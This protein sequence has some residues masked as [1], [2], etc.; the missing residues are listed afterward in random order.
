MLPWQREYFSSVLMGEKPPLDSSLSDSAGQIKLQSPHFI[1]PCCYR[2]L[3][4]E[5][6]HRLKRRRDAGG[7]V[8]QLRDIS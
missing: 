5:F 2:R 1:S 3:G 4:L 7:V 6:P 8:I